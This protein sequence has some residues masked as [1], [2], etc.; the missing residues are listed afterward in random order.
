MRIKKLA[1]L[2][3]SVAALATASSAFAGGG[4]YGY[5]DGY[6][7]GDYGYRDGYRHSRHYHRDRVVV[8]PII[9]PR[10]AYYYTPAPVYYAPAPTY[11][12]PAPAYYAP[13]PVYY[14]AAGPATVGGAIAGAIIGNHIADRHHRGAATFAGALIGGAIGSSID[15]GY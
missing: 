15:Y 3:G 9:A 14:G 13:A 1:V 4:Y 2:A 7:G 5:R 6:R 12:A 11:Y 8:R 10:P